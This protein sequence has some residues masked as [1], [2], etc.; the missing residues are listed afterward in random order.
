[1]SPKPAQT[2]IVGGGPTGSLLAI[3]LARRGIEAVVLEREPAWSRQRQPEGR[4]INLALAARGIHALQ[5]ADAYTAVAALAIPMR[6]RMLHEAGMPQRF[7]PYG[8]HPQDCIYSISRADLHLALYRLATR[9]YGVEYRFEHECTHVDAAAR[10]LRVTSSSGERELEFAV[11]FGCD[12]AGSQVRRALSEA[13]M[14]AASEELL[15][16]GYKEFHIPPT[17]ADEYALDPSA[18]H[19][20]PRGD[21]MLIALPNLDRSFT[22]T[23]FL[24]LEGEIGFASLTTETIG[25]F[26]ASEFPDAG[27]LMPELEN[28]FATHP[29]GSL[30]T[31]RCEPFS[32]AG[33]VL[34]L[35]D[36]GHAIVPFHGQGMNAA[37]EDCFAL[38]G[39]VAMHGPSWAPVSSAFDSERRPNA[40][41]IA[42][43]AL[44]NYAEM[45]DQVRDPGF[46]LRLELGLELERR[47]PN[48]FV[49]RYAMVMF[50]PEISYATAQ[51]RGR[52]QA[53]ILQRLTHGVRSLE[54]VD[55]ELA[56]EL[57]DTQLHPTPGWL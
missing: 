12:G 56:A 11:L 18:L 47:F 28:E 35:G 31:I 7:A 49:P 41:A 33:R 57:I 26:F 52:V 17:A 32:A 24:P 13:G 6:G 21:F 9:E 15:D 34:L 23:L 48:R 20:W 16:H 37:F 22:A 27:M 38:D 19:I 39:L 8:Q 51:E 4:S 44:E 40:R 3:L 54:D 5:A 25:D 1:M 53:Q 14:V 45:R 43:M 42:T 50:H 30:G 55:Y 2:V 36:A 46:N 10:R 29:T